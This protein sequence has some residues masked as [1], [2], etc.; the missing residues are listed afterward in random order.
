[1]QKED[2]P[3]EAPYDVL[4]KSDSLLLHQ[5]SDHVAQHGPDSIESFVRMAYI[6]KSSVIKKNFLYDEN[7]HCFAQLRTCLHDP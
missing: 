3:K 4:Q 2:I 5:L 6:S 1:M 7:S